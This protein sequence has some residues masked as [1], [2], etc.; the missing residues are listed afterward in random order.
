MPSWQLWYRL[1]SEV[2]FLQV[3]LIGAQLPLGVHIPMFEN[4]WKSKM[5]KGTFP[6]WTKLWNLDLNQSH[7]LLVTS[8]AHRL[9]TFSKTSVFTALCT[10]IV[11][12]QISHFPLGFNQREKCGRYY[13]VGLKG[14]P[15][16][17]LYRNEDKNIGKKAWPA[18]NPI[19][20]LLYNNFR[21]KGLSFHVK[22][23]DISVLNI[24]S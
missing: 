10:A 16:F 3:P 23:R 15:K 9:K 8:W 13:V 21:K 18:S 2:E 7:K 11:T 6:Y 17:E 20:V 12:F 4:H 14:T 1:E 19:K 22:W 24:P 5:F